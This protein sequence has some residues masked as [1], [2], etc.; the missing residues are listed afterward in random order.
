MKMQFNSFLQLGP[1]YVV[2]HRGVGGLVEMT[3]ASRGIGPVTFS[4]GMDL[5]DR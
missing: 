1:R 2:E 4:V 5:G 3:V